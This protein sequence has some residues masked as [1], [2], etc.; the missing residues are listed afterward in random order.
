MIS[1]L[2]L[3]LYC[4]AISIVA[5]QGT[6]D[7]F[8]GSGDG[9]DLFGG[10]GDGGDCQCINGGVCQIDGTCDCP[11][12]FGGSQCQIPLTEVSCHS[13]S[14]VVYIKRELSQGTNLGDI[15]FRKISCQS[16]DDDAYFLLQTA[17]D[18]CGTTRTETDT[19]IIFSNVITY[20]KPGPISGTGITREYQKQFE[21]SCCLDKTSLVD[22]Q[23]F[24]PKLG[25]VQ[26]N[27]KGSG[28]FR[29]KMIRLKSSEEPE[30]DNAEVLQGDALSFRVRL[31]SVEEV[32][33]FIE[34][35]WAT[36]GPG[37]DSTP[38]HDLF[39]NRCPSNVDET[40]KVFFP[41]RTDREKFQ[42]D[43]FAF[44]GDHSMVYIHCEVR[45]CLIKEAIQNRD[46]SGTSPG[47]ERRSS[48]FLS[49]Q[50]ISSAP[51]RVRRSTNDMATN[52]LSA[53]NSFGMFLIGM[54]ATVVAVATLM[55]VVKLIRRPT[56][57]SYK[58]VPTA[59]LEGI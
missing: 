34:E 3:A 49:T 14:M 7:L 37:H 10:S 38:R 8:G 56:D 6:E 47:R 48:S 4:Y 21:V 32:G 2:R 11:E 57:I 58:R 13:D 31:R 24:K 25:Q 41:P 36:A 51:V 23:S 53:Y 45:V 15:H 12:E 17:Y 29:L 35:C 28:Q 33:M 46:C 1:L 16:V 5:G 18:E 55:G 50:T 59:S 52:D 44:V 27:D 30:D 54:V 20:Y 26:F 19:T 43:A 40:V 42:F 39:T 22:G 9:E